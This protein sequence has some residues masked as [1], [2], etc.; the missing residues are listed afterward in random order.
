MKN[1]LTP[2]CA[3]G[4]DILFEKHQGPLAP[5]FTFVQNVEESRPSR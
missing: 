1:R 5:L 2:V 4:G 3:G